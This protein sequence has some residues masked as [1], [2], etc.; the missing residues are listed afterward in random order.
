[1]I[2]DEVYVEIELLRKHGMSLRK[3]AEAVG[4]AAAR[5]LCAIMNTPCTRKH[6]QCACPTSAKS[7]ASGLASFVDW[8]PVM[9]LPVNHEAS[10]C[11]E[12]SGADYDILSLLP[13]IIVFIL[14]ASEQ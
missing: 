5:V 13:G 2:T 12:S 11:G 3:I 8:M 7:L 14:G 6:I 4:C 1:M 10:R 9:V